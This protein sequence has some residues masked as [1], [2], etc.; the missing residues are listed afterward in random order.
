MILENIVMLLEQMQWLV[1]VTQ[2]ISVKV[3]QVQPS[4]KE[5]FVPKDIN[6]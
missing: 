5:E 3:E 4:Q 6:A 1:I 2:G